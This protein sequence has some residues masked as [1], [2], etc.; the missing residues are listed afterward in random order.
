MS[1]YILFMA[2]ENY[3]VIYGNLFTAKQ[4][5]NILV[6]TVHDLYKELLELFE[7]YE[8]ALE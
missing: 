6:R 8:G 4:R 2:Y 5:V 3:F 1:S 7:S